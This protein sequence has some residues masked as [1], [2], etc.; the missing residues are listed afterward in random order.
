MNGGGGGGGFDLSSTS[1]CSSDSSVHSTQ[2]KKSKTSSSS[3]SSSVSEDVN[4]LSS[5][6]PNIV[7][8]KVGNEKSKSYLQLTSKEPVF[9][10]NSYRLNFH[11]RVKLP[12]VKNYQLIEPTNIDNVWT[13]FGKVTDDKFHLDYKEPLDTFLAFAVAI[14]QFDY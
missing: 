10:K 7:K 4:A 1:V 13:Q 2:K 11:G 3:S 12:S 9:E 5:V 8:G 6:K 14:T